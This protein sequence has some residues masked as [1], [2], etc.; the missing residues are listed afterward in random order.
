MLKQSLRLFILP[1]G[2]VSAMATM[3]GQ[4]VPQAPRDGM[5]QQVRQEIVTCAPNAGGAACIVVEKAR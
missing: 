4:N 3:A 5:I 1:L 2:A